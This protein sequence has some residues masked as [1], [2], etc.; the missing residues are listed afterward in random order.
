VCWKEGRERNDV[1]VGALD[2]N[3][4]EGDGP[5]PLPGLSGSTPRFFMGADHTD[6]VFR[7]EVV[8]NTRVVLIAVHV[9]PVSIHEVE[10][11][12]QLLAS[13]AELWLAQNTL[14]RIWSKFQSGRAAFESV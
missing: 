13:S 12:N 6:F 1:H 7:I 8:V 11:L 5:G 4:I 10:T 9:G 2:R 14:P 3:A